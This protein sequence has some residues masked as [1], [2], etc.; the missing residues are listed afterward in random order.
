[1]NDNV[2]IKAPQ[3]SPLGL[4]ILLC[5]AFL[6]V[7]DV[8]VVNLAIPSIQKNM[9]TDLSE[10]S[11][12]IAV[13]SLVF[14]SCLVIGGRLGDRYGRQRMFSLGLFTFSLI[15]FGCGLAPSTYFLIFVRAL[16]G[17]SAA[18]L[19]PQIYTLL[20]V[21]YD[22][23]GRTRA[24]G[25][26][27]VTL[28]MGAIAGQVF[29]GF[30]VWG[31]L[32]DLGWRLIFLINLPFGIIAG[33]LAKKI[34]ESCGLSTNLDLVGALFI[35]CCIGLFLISVLEGPAQGWPMWTVIC[36]ICSPCIGGMFIFVERRIKYSGKMPIIDMA[37]LSN[38]RFS[39]VLITIV[40]IY[41]TPSSLFLCFSLT[42]QNGF[43]ETPLTVGILLMPMSIGLIIASFM[44]ARL[45]KYFGNVAVIS[46]MILYAIGFLWMAWLAPRTGIMALKQA[47]YLMGMII[48]GFGQGISG[49][50]LLNLAIGSVSKEY[51]GMAGGIV[52][53]AQQLG[54][55][56]GV[57][58][59]TLIFSLALKAS[60]AKYSNFDS[61]NWA[62]AIILSW[63]AFL[64][65][66][67]AALIT[68]SNMRYNKTTYS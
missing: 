42:A 27:G 15:S 41:S 10:G 23:A 62:L 46:G 66:V 68:F 19:F 17:I 8:F 32:F 37:L 5:G 53:T 18:L 65:L 39:I 64:I 40:L 16:Q 13:Y 58:L 51:A 34:P 20:H 4:V 29:G 54:M 56:I 31:N 14:G 61:Y 48:F 59:G 55:A 57:G 60:L 44:S 47:S 38:K 3:L 67:S 52:S 30:L 63:N 9:G 7:F 45:V 24:F 12:I 35:T 6:V 21:L 36:L 50:P 11:L 22:E 28:G 49:P 43:G 2:N 33:I 1:M 26:L 25:A